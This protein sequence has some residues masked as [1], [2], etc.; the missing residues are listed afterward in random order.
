MAR[1]DLNYK[2]IADACQQLFADGK[3]TSFDA[4]YDLIGRRG[5]AAKVRDY[6]KQWRQAMAD[7]LNTP[8]ASAVLPEALVG[9]A[10]QLIEQIWTQALTQADTAYL[11]KQQALEAERITWGE[12]IDAAETRADDINRQLLVARGEVQTKEATID[13][14][15]RQLEELRGKLANAVQVIAQKDELTLR[16]H[17]EIEALKTNL[18]A[19]RTRHDEVL[20]SERAHSQAALAAEQD[21]HA[22]ELKSTVEAAEGLR[23]HLMMQTDEVRQAARQREL[24]LN[25]QLTEQ[26]EFTD[27]FKRRATAA[28]DKL[29]EARG[30]SALLSKQ[31]AAT[32]ARLE[33]LVGQLG[34]ANARHSEQASTIAVLQA[35]V[36]DLQASA[37]TAM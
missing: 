19:E 9:F 15:T 34:A 10:D 1:E 12:R 23:K 35:Q 30:E 32:N 25:A 14:L 31:L 6:I 24:A 21:R 20:A 37:G 16:Q 11:E 33:E 2:L 4:V 18:A 8:R 27:G 5:S 36:A 13:G 22:A 17:G 7:L 29:A 3:H 26:K 28:E